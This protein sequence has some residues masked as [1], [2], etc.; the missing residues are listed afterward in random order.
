[1]PGPLPPI[2]APSLPSVRLGREREK[3]WTWLCWSPAVRLSSLSMNGPNRLKPELQLLCFF[4]DRPPHV[5]ATVGAD[6]V[7]GDGVP[8]LRAIGQLLGLFVIVGAAAASF[9]VR[10]SSLRDGHDKFLC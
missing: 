10:L 4:H 9:L 1:R 8:A 3:Q 6:C 5:M 2:R 7:R